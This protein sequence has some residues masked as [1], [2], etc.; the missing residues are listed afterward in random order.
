MSYVVLS[1]DTTESDL[2]QRREIR[3]RS[4]VFVDAPPLEAALEGRLLILDG[5]EKVERN[6]LL[7]PNFQVRIFRTPNL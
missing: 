5:L 3:S 1:P 2:K 4:A 6:V 7:V